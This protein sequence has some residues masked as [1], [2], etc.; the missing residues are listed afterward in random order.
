MMAEL[1]EAVEKM[2]Q[3]EPDFDLNTIGERLNSEYE[4]YR[5]SYMKY[6]KL[7]NK[8][9]DVILKLKETEKFA[10]DSACCFIRVTAMVRKALREFEWD[11]GK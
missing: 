7:R 3:S 11:D 9:V 2:V 1:E 10:M 8:D 5:E 4:A 6:K